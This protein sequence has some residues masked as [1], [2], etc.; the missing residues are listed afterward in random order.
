M[1]DRQARYDRASLTLPSRLPWPKAKA[2]LRVMLDSLAASLVVTEDG[3][4]FLLQRKLLQLPF[5]PLD[6]QA[7]ATVA[8]FIAVV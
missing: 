4:G 6:E 1:R 2:L 8:K 5:A 3:V 7:Q